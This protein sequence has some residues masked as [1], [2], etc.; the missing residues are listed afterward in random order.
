MASYGCSECLCI[1]I[2]SHRPA[3][4]SELLGRDVVYRDMY[5][6]TRPLAL[7]RSEIRVESY[8]DE[9]FPVLH[10][11]CPH[12]DLSNV[13]RADCGHVVVDVE[14]R[15]PL[16]Y[17]YAAR[18]L[19]SLP[20][21]ARWHSCEQ[22]LR[23]SGKFDYSEPQFFHTFVKFT[24]PVSED[25]DGDDSDHSDDSDYY[26][27]L[28][29]HE[30]HANYE[31]TLCLAFETLPSKNFVIDSRRAPLLVYELTSSAADLVTVEG[32]VDRWRTRFS[33]QFGTLATVFKNSAADGMWA[34]DSHF[35]RDVQTQLEC[36]ADLNRL[37]LRTCAQDG[38]TRAVYRF[39]RAESV[40]SVAWQTAICCSVATSSKPRVA[41]RFNDLMQFLLRHGLSVFIACELHEEVTY[42]VGDHYLD[43]L[44]SRTCV[45][46][47][48]FS[49]GVAEQLLSLGYG[50][51][52]LRHAGFPILDANLG[53]TRKAIE[54][55]QTT[56][57]EV[58]ARELQ[59]LVTRFDA[60]PLTLRELS[61]VA[62]RR[63]VGGSDFARRVRAL[64]PQRSVLPPALYNFVSD[65]TELMLS[66]AELKR[67]VEQ[68]PNPCAIQ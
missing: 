28:C 9:Y 27:E 22:M 61:R 29:E 2:E 35:L 24:P 25:E 39:V 30:L 7:R 4:L 67:L 33:K 42:P 18:T 5:W 66:V 50:R 59:S 10:L 8:D 62:I 48:P 52:E 26:Y 68:P 23:E 6:S 14:L 16:R 11:M 12:A 63:A 15:K 3:L 56:G 13:G 34:S 20:M 55:H 32:L 40:L 53:D 38:S 37:F 44:F 49:R 58:V 57:K 47:W 60:G 17:Q 54:K 64:G 45:A 1:A 65:S 36:G 21:M 43:Q 19:V 51:R 41:L 31:Q 46:L